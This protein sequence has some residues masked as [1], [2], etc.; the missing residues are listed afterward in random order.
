MTTDAGSVLE[1]LHDEPPHTDTTG[2]AEGPPHIGPEG[3]YLTEAPR[4]PEI[5]DGFWIDQFAVAQWLA[6]SQWTTAP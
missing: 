4:D 3:S 2:A 6:A 5:A 1:P